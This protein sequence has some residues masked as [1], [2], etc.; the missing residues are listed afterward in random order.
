MLDQ[1]I[2]GLV[3][4]N[5]YALTAVGITQIYGVANVINFAH[6]SLY[7]V[8]AFVGWMAVTWLGLP[9]LPTL[10]LVLVASALLGLAVE[11]VAIRPFAGSGRT[12]LLLTTIAAGLV[13]EQAAQLIWG[14]ETKAFH[15]PFADVRVR[16]GGGF[17]S[18]LDLVILAVGLTTALALW[19]FLKRSRLGWAVRAT[20]QDRE[21]ALQM[22]VDV[23]QVSRVSFAMAGALAGV[24]GLLVGLYYH[25]V[26]PTMGFSAS[27]KGFTAA[28]LGGLGNIPGALVGAYLLGTAES[29]AVAWLG[30]T[31]RDLVG[32]GL[33]L[34]VLL[35]RPNG[36][37]AAARALLPE[38]TAGTFIPI[39][40]PLPIPRWALPAAGAVALALPL[41]VRNGY[42]LQVLAT[43]WIFGLL[44]ISLNLIAGTAGQI[45]LG[46][47]GFLALGAYASAILTTR[48]QWPFLLSLAVAPVIA[49][50]VGVV[51][52][53]P[54]LRLR[55]QYLA[56]ATIGLG[57]GIALVALNWTALTRGPLGISNIAPPGL[58]GVEITSAAG[59]YWLTLTLLLGGIWVAERLSG[60]Y[61]GRA[62]R[63]VR[64]DE[65]AARAY[66]VGLERYKSIAFGLSA[67]IAGLAGVL[68]AHAYTYIAP[69]T[70]THAMSLQVLTMV[71]LG[72]LDNT[73][74][75]VAG[76][77]ALIVIPESARFLAEYRFL[78]YGLLLLV[79]LRFRPRGLLSAAS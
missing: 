1:L 51:L 5:L 56:V 78:V 70:F 60:S 19:L 9:L 79:M 53:Y 35:F 2:N 21:A 65:V 64:E 45:S 50:A 48:L 58:F 10:L 55:G 49:A 15:T 75:A 12:V 61:L 54:A 14:P 71:V 44:A 3:V 8:G 63:A 16:V 47:A 59:F 76:A 74:G 20:A 22:G 29:L 34:G 27:L 39:G 17:L 30:S 6:G 40:R 42:W 13:L 28:L 11:R 37:F 68:L 24:S 4:G 72:G 32:I 18:S 77:L 57:Q 67:F 69:D 7:M 25:S 33:L 31:W 52:C 23:N 38:P 62:L 36:L 73:I 66:G 26:Y 43:A 46:H 41:V